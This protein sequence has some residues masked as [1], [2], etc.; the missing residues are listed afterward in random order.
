M[1]AIYKCKGNIWQ[2]TMLSVFKENYTK[3]RQVFVIEAI[4]LKKA[5]NVAGRWM[6]TMT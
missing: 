1:K 6:A 5:Y 4:A 3:I 2:T